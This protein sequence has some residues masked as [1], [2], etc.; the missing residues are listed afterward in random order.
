[1]AIPLHFEILLRT[2]WNDDYRRGARRLGLMGFDELR[3]VSRPF[4]V[5]LRH[6]V[7]SFRIWVQEELELEFP[8]LRPYVPPELKL[9]VYRAD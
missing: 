5:V 6:V 3:K 7:V 2:R 9:V 4:N 8:H 1:M